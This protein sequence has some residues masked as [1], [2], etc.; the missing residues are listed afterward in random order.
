MLPQTTREKL[1]QQIAARHEVYNMHHQA[2]LVLT[3]LFAKHIKRA[4]RVL[5][6]TAAAQQRVAA[7]QEDSHGSKP[8]GYI[9]NVSSKAVPAWRQPLRGMQV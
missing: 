5:Q 3:A 7:E 6:A 4:S 1:L 9:R 2:T 8:S